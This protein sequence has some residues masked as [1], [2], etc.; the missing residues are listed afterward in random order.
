MPITE[1]FNEDCLKA[2]KRYPDKYFDLACVDPPYFS[3]P[4]KRLYYGEEVNKLNIRRKTYPLIKKWKLPTARYFKELNR[5][6]KNQIV[7]GCNY[8]KY[9]FGPGRIIWDKCNGTS[10]F[11][12]AEE[13]YCSMYDSVRLF[14][15]MWNGM[16]QGKSMTEGRKMQG[17]KSKNEIRIHATQKPVVLY[18]WLFQKHCKP[19]WKILDTHLGSQSSRIAAFDMDFDFFGFELDEQTFE[20]GNERFKLHI[21]NQKIKFPKELSDLKQMVLI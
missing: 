18:Q 7:W 15:F 14:P 9:H 21:E 4:E 20:E 10:S 12:D 8:F 11:S 2:M 16:L 6:S 3:G 19:G 13:A 1:T 17:D 5:V